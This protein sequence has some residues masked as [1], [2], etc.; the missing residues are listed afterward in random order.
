MPTIVLEAEGEPLRD[1]ALLN[2]LSKAVSR[3]DRRAIHEICGFLCDRYPLMQR[4]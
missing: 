3:G 4:A 2:A 1:S